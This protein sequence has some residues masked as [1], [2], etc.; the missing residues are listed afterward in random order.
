MAIAIAPSSACNL[1]F[2][3]TNKNSNFLFLTPRCP[4]EKRKL[5]YKERNK[6]NK[7]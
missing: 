6:E 4:Q 1:N 7:N 3:T 2:T 5:Y